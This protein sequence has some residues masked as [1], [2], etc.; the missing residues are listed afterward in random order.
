MVERKELSRVIYE[1]D[2]NI[3]T[4]TLNYPEKLNA[5]DFPGDGGICDGFYKDAQGV[6][7]GRA[8]KAVRK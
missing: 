4:I 3:A 8:L 1:K 5:M 6:W 2:G 7:K